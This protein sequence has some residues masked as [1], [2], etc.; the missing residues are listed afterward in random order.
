[1][2]QAPR[3]LIARVDPRIGAVL[4]DLR[5]LAYTGGADPEEDQPGYVRAA[6]AIRRLGDRLVIVQDDTSVLAILRGGRVDPLLLPRGAGGRRVF[7]DDLGNKHDKMDLEACAALPDGRLVAFGSGSLPPREVLVVIEP[8]LSTRV[9][10]G[11]PLYRILREELAFSG[12][13][14]NVEGALVVGDRL[15]LFQRGNGAPRGG[16]QPVDATGDLPLAAFLGWLDGGGQAP[17]LTDV[18]QVDLGA[19]AGVRLTFTDAALTAAGQ[20][21]FLA[22]A[23]DSPDSIRDGEV[24]GCRVGVMEGAEVRAADVVDEAG[25]PVRLKLEG[26]ERRPDGDYDVVADMDITGEP[27]VIGRLRVTGPGF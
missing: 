2:A 3:R 10:D 25:R 15:R 1:V 20:V 26:I 14:L 23:E 13:E 19:V 8:D 4:S 21:A 27:A 11:A 22:C 12:P 16:L 24:V 17:E 18:V 5:P 6:S 7:G 9:V